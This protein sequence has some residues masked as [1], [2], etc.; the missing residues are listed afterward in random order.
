MG[1]DFRENDDIPSL[2]MYLVSSVNK[3]CLFVRVIAP[4]YIM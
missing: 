3:P 4:G 1:N 2:R